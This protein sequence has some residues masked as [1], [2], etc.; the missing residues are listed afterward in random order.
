[1]CTP[2]SRSKPVPP[3][4][5]D[6]LSLHH[7]TSMQSI[8]DGV[9][10]SSKTSFSNHTQGS[11]LQTWPPSDNDLHQ[12]RVTSEYSNYHENGDG[13]VTMILNEDP[14]RQR[15]SPQDAHS[16]S[17]K[18]IWTSVRDSRSRMRR[19]QSPDSALH[20]DGDHSYDSSQD[21]YGYAGYSYSNSQNHRYHD[22]HKSQPNG[23]CR[24]VMRN[25]SKAPHSP[26]SLSVATVSPRPHEQWC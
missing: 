2:S 16:P 11:I 18:E 3:K 25:G 14:V 4:K 23:Q 5:P 19:S 26:A 6:R 1:E 22:S 24:N 15:L 12:S 9:R 17:I 21:I 8:E 20:L 10:S 7:T 13:G